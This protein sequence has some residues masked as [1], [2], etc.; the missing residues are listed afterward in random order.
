MM[1][2]Y[3]ANRKKV[4]YGRR[5]LKIS[6]ISISKKISEIIFSFIKNIIELVDLIARNSHIN[7]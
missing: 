7:L 5:L 2:R 1:N 6:D 4:L 3:F